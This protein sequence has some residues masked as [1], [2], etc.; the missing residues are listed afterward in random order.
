MSS[1]DF[2][3]SSYDFHIM[4][5]RRWITIGI[6]TQYSIKNTFVALSLCIPIFGAIFFGK[7]GFQK[8]KPMIITIKRAY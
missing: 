4:D 6:V 3:V 7:F 1:A 5:I 2:I 8:Q